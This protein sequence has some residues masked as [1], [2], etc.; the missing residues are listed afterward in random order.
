MTRI[1]LATDLDRTVLPNGAQEESP[2]ARTLFRRLAERPEVTLAYVSGRGRA[3]LEEALDTY[4]IPVPAYAIGD[5]G[6]T[7]FDLTSG[8]WSVMDAWSTRIAADWNGYDHDRMHELFADIAEI[9]LQEDA[10][11]NTFKVSYYAPTDT[12]HRA[13]RERMQRLLTE[14]GIRAALMWSIDEPARIGL[15]DVLPASATKLHA[16][17]FLREHLGIPED[18]TIACG[19]SGNDIPVLASGLKAVLVRN[20]RPEV[21]DEIASLLAA[22]GKADRLYVAR[23]G[24]LGMNGN[25]AAGVVEG[26]AH[27]VPQVTEWL[28]GRG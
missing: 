5:V 26:A 10:K 2:D 8:E 3:L 17:Q 20:A 19:D 14:R 25:Y 12:D 7:M 21:Q 18:D 24:Y 4:G 13:L 23:G 6:T 15:L 11:Q 9:R 16:V 22:Q 28:E 27:Y 1:L